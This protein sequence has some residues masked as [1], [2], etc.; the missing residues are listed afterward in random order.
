MARQRAPWEQ[1]ALRML[2]F[3]AYPALA[4]AAFCVLSL[5]V[6]TWVPALAAMARTLRQWRTDGHT[7]CFVGVFATFGP[8]WRVLWRHGVVSTVAIL[9]LAVNLLF[10]AGRPS[11]MAFALLATQVGILLVLVPYHL[12]LAA[13]AAHAPDAE[14]TVWRA[15]AVLLAFG[16]AR[17]GLSLLAVAI[18]APVFTVVIPFG[19]FLLG[20][21][22]PVLAAITMA[23]RL[24]PAGD[25]R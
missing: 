13:A 14:V 17:R 25:R 24:W 23:D 10:L 22:L 4:G 11:P 20:P 18:A 3:L 16:S 19:P 6:V 1:S 8:Y 21:S 9:L 12:A 15:A 5:G 2:E 7:K